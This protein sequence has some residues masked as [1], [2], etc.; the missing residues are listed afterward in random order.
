MPD[1]EPTK[2]ELEVPDQQL[3]DELMGEPQLDSAT[4]QEE[5]GSP[6]AGVQLAEAEQR[7]LRA[8][9]ELENFRKRMRREMDEE[10]RYANLPF[11]ADLLPVVDNLERAI[12][13]AEVA[14]QHGP[15]LDGVRIVV[16]QLAAVLEKYHCQ[17][18]AAEGQ[19]FDPNLHQAIAQIPSDQHAAGHVTQVAVAGYRLHDRVVRPAQVLVAAD[20]PQP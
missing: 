17:R 7:V 6:S 14:N 13:S 2:P 10:R 18:I 12:Q 5:V 16:T 20:Q 3:V 4:G 11:V 19:P 8:Q 15:L 9:A 1:H